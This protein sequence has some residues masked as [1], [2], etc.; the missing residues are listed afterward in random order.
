MQ[1]DLNRKPHGVVGDRAWTV[2]IDR[3]VYS[4][5]ES[6]KELHSSL[7]SKDI[8]GME[9]IKGEIEK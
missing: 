3:V 5:E 7:L 4:S 9:S 6:V 1:Q 8:H 2:K